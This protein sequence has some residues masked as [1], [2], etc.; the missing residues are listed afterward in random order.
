MEEGNGGRLDPFERHNVYKV[1]PQPEEKIA[2]S[3][4]YVFTGKRN[5]EGEVV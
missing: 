2:V 3:C 4:K 1:V 5:N